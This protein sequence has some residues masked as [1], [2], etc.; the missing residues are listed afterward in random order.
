MLQVHTDGWPYFSPI[1]APPHRSGGGH[2]V[3][4]VLRNSDHSAVS[5]DT[6]RH[7]WAENG[8]LYYRAGGCTSA[9]SPTDSLSN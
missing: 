4:N 7:L 5:T 2:P 8:H 9:D 1:S 6:E 3:F